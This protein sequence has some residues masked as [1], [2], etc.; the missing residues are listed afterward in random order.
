M[1]DTFRKVYKT[2]KQE[3]TDLIISIKEK[4]EEL[5]WLFNKVANR[6]MS[7]AKTNLETSIMWATKAI[8]LSD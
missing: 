1:A 7:V 4:A 5:E 2:L 3:N 6:E 8:V